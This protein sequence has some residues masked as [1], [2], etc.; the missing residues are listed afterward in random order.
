MRLPS[1]CYNWE[2]EEK[3]P[4]KYYCVVRIKKH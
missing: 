1:Y 2:C 4:E 3:L